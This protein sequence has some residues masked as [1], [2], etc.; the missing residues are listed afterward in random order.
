LSK[1]G[2]PTWKSLKQKTKARVK[3]LAFDL[4]KL[5]AQ[6]KQQ[7]VLPILLILICKMNWR[8]VSL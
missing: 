6:R 4:I 8:Q 1:L 7:K 3:Q 5:Y 2:S